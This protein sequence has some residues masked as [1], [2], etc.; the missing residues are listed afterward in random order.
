MFAG[1]F[2]GVLL[3][4]FALD[5]QLEEGFLHV[6]G[7]AAV[8]VFQLGPGL[9]V[10][11]DQGEEFFD[12]RDDA[13]LFGEGREGERGTVESFVAD[14]RIGYAFC[15]FGTVCIAVKIRGEQKMKK[16]PIV[17]TIGT[18]HDCKTRA[19]NRFTGELAVNHANIVQVGANGRIDD[20]A[21]TDNF[22][23]TRRSILWMDDGF[24]TGKPLVLVV[25][26][27]NVN[28]GEIGCGFLLAVIENHI[29]QTGPA[30]GFGDVE[31]GL[32]AGRERGTWDGGLKTSGEG[33]GGLGSSGRGGFRGAE[34]GGG[35][36][37][38][39]ALGNELALDGELEDG[40][41]EGLWGHGEG[42]G[43]SL[44]SGV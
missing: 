17:Q 30:P 3:H 35:G 9:F 38:F 24:V 2:F 11:V 4:Q 41:F 23:G 28:V 18:G 36:A 33:E 34:E 20:V 7:K 44:K 32:G 15:I 10:A 12:F 16:E 19:G 40:G 37:F 5:G 39:G 8:E 31:E 13:V 29:A 26:G 25:N 43:L 14:G 42:K 1:A 21:L 27:A 6:D 22:A